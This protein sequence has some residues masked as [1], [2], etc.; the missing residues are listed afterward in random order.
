MIN[1]RSTA[2]QRHRQWANNE[3]QPTND[4]QQYG[5]IKNNAQTT[6]NNAMTE[7]KEGLR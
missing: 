5:T 7:T 6:Q 1:P 4:H 2:K 3:K